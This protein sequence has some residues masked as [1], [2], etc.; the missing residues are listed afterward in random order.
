MDKLHYSFSLASEEVYE[1]WATTLSTI[2][3]IN[4]PGDV[5]VKY[6]PIWVGLYDWYIFE[7]LG[8]S[9]NAI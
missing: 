2:T 8:I 9:L 6:H 1:V 3:V 4:A 5:K 7:K